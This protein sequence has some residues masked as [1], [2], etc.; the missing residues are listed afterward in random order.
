MANSKRDKLA[1]LRAARAGTAISEVYEQPKYNSIYEEVDEDTYRKRKRDQLLKEDFVVNDVNNDYFDDGTESWVSNDSKKQISKNASTKHNKAEYHTDDDDD[2][3]DMEEKENESVSRGVSI[4]KYFQPSSSKT[5]SSFKSSKRKQKLEDFSIDDILDD[6]DNESP[7]TKKLKKGLRSLKIKEEKDEDDDDEELSALLF[8]EPTKNS[9]NKSKKLTNSHANK[10]DTSSTEIPSHDIKIENPSPIKESETI[11]ISPDDGDDSKAE[12]PKT[13]NSKSSNEKI[14]F[15]QKDAENEDDEEDDDI[16]VARRPRHTA[17]NIK[18]SINMQSLKSIDIFLKK[19]QQ[20]DEKMSYDENDITLDD[21]DD[22]IDAA[23][24]R[25]DNNTH[26]SVSSNSSFST[27]KKILEDDVLDEN[28]NFLMYWMDYAETDTSLLLF[29][30]VKT[31]DSRF[32]SNIL[33]IKGLCKELYFLPRKI[34]INDDEDDLI[35]ETEV[36][37]SSDVHDEIV[38]LILEKFGLESIR[39]KAETK[40]YAFE[41]PSI[42]KSHEYLKV[43]MP[44]DTPKSKN[45]NLPSDLAGETFSKVFGTTTGIFESFILQRNIMGPCWLEISNGNFQ[46]LQNTSHT[47]LEVSV[48]NP[49][50][51]QPLSLE[52]RKEKNLPQS[53]PFNLL[54]LNVTPIF[55]EKLNKQEVAC[56]TIS[57]FV[58]VDINNIASDLK[59]RETLTL[60]KPVGILKSSFPP[61]L[62]KI[63]NESKINIRTFPTEKTLINCLCALVKRYDPDFLIGHNLETSTLDIL[64]HRMHELRVSNWSYFGRRN[65]KAWPE[66]LFKMGGTSG[67]SFMN[68][69][70]LKEIFQGR[71]LCDISNELGKSVTLKCQNW[72]LP[73]MYDVVCKKKIFNVE[74]NLNHSQYS[75]DAKS[76]V[77]VLFEAQRRTNVAMEIAFQLQILSLSRTLTN[78]AGNAWSHTLGGTRSGRS[79]FFLLHEFTRNNFIVPDRTFGSLR[80][81]KSETSARADTDDNQQ[82]TKS[83]NNKKSQYKGGLVLDPEVGLHKTYIIVMD[84]NSLYPS[85]IQE[86]NICFTTVDRDEFNKHNQDEG[87]LPDLPAADIPK[88]I[89]PK[90]LHS[91]VSSRKEVKKLLKDPTISSSEKASYDI[92]QLALKLQANSLYGYLGYEKSRFYAKA[93]AMLITAKGREILME[94]KKMSESIDLHTIYGDTDSLMIETGSLDYKEALEYASKFQQLVNSKHTVLELGLDNVYKSI[95]LHAKKKYAAV[96]VILNEDGETFSEKLEI[97]GLDLKRR[98]YS[99]LTKEVS[100]F[101]LKK[102]LSDQDAEEVLSEIYEYLTELT[103]K[104]KNNDI[105]PE[106]FK[107]NTKLSKDPKNYPGGKN[108]PQVQV[109]LRLRKQGKIIKAGSVI[110]YIICADDEGSPA[111]RAR[112]LQEVLAKNSELKP[113]PIYYLEKQLF[114][115]LERLLQTYPGIDMVRLANCLGL[116][117]RKYERHNTS[118]QSSLNGLQTFES[119]VSDELRYKYS[120]FLELQCSCGFKFR[121]GGIVPSFDYKMSLTGIMC[122]RCNKTMGALRV[123]SQLER[124]IRSFI[125]LYYASW[126]VCDDPSCGLTTRQMGVYGRKCFAEDCKGLMRYKF[127]DQELYRQ[128]MYFHSIFDS[129]K[130][131]KNV[132]KQIYSVGADKPEPINPSQVNILSEQNRDFFKLCQNIVDKYLNISARRFVDM[133]SIFGYMVLNESK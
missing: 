63:A 105:R 14:G 103:N 22:D 43:L 28:G 132:L 127:N 114:N 78:I 86:Y 131:K 42:P 64:I 115:P 97:K 45:V 31:K 57:N 111:D 49:T 30:K 58:D 87:F 48:S 17:K 104:I 110:T 70:R 11:L 8:K 99:P 72:D 116:D 68:N 109:A 10:T 7:A 92:K 25:S 13:E 60:V 74:I 107:I 66:K 129:D 12:N 118:N 4:S 125:S 89:L 27:T 81:N 133:G 5:S 40:K 23:S 26:F 121:F 59:P 98:E 54:A 61:G 94:T 21:Y 128:L 91:L 112:S 32:I 102:I 29:G 24:T 46:E 75:E 20:Q 83:S 36:V 6:F 88:G 50:F 95:L 69:L 52:A 122:S 16:I 19:R 85:I 100:N 51:V 123:T 96:D 38:P 18:R 56:V 47:S 82:T 120:K 79:E 41:L 33:Q 3:D 126:L 9:Q 65:R 73:D 1:A 53:P 35:D 34:R 76:L 113:D 90:L 62:Q 124:E 101:I 93:L 119:T 84:F 106:K 108:M 39:S 44:F 80:I 130:N 2:D 55:N 15:A 117:G 67:S 37:T 71:L 77:S